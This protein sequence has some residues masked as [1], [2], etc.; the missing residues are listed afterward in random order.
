MPLVIYKVPP[1]VAFMVQYQGEKVAIYH[2]Y[3]DDIQRTTA[4]SVYTA[5][6]K[7]GVRTDHQKLADGIVGA[8]G[9]TRGDDDDRN[10]F[11]FTTHNLFKMMKALPEFQDECKPFKR[12]Y[13][14]EWEDKYIVQTAI[15]Y[16]L[17]GFDEDFRFVDTTM[18]E[19][20][21]KSCT[22]GLIQPYD[23]KS[24]V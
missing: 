1:D 24:A 12:R 10:E 8:Y 13:S 6:E 5:D 14:F 4:D 3:I 23:V 20:P 17:V 2:T 15:D 18:I 16:G 7:E 11:W 21:V 9:F 22:G 19:E